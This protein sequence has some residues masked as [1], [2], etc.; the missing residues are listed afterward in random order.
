M[1]YLFYLIF[2]IILVIFDQISK[3]YII[4]NYNLSTKNVV[5]DG[6]FN[7]THV[8]NY[9]AGFSIMQNQRLFL[10]LVSACAIILFTYLLI[11]EKNKFNIFTYL[12]IISG[13]IGNLI[14]RC[15][16]G[17]VIDFLDFYIFGYD[18]PV[19]NI[20]D[21]FITIGCFLLIINIF[22]EEKNAKN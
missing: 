17:Y 3:F 22:L 18:F 20:A 13:S 21:C 19:F 16:L 9:G 11:K 15:R 2:I 10:V 7:I 5:I 12:L 4:N 14:D 1:Y 6:F 8:R